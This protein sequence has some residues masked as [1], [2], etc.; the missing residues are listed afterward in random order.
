MDTRLFQE[1]DSMKTEKTRLF[2]PA[3]TVVVSHK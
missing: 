3:H 2:G 1:A